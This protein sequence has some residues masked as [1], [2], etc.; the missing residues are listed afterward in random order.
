[1]VV[2]KTIQVFVKLPDGRTVPVSVTSTDPVSS[3]LTVLA[4]K[5]DLDADSYHYHVRIFHS[6]L[7]VIQYINILMPLTIPYSTITSIS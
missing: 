5:E 7:N 2:P 3:V 1:M 4:D 6:F